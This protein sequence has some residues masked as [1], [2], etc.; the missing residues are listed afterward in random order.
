MRDLCCGLRSDIV[1]VMKA[2]LLFRRECVN[3]GSHVQNV[4][5]WCMQK[6]L[7]Y[8]KL[9]AIVDLEQHIKYE[10]ASFIPFRDIADP[11][12]LLAQLDKLAAMVAVMTNVAFV[13]QALEVTSESNLYSKTQEM[14]MGLFSD[15]NAVPD[16]H[17]PSCLR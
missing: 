13:A 9:L 4:Q 16:I 17:A 7:S 15:V 2:T 10:L 3:S 6:C 8:D 14:A 11:S 1:A 5:Q 12:R